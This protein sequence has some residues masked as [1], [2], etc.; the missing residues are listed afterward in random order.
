MHFWVA[1]KKEPKLPVIGIV[2]VGLLCVGESAEAIYASIKVMISQVVRSA[3][4]V[5]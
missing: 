3:R 2:K 1:A 4:K 5:A